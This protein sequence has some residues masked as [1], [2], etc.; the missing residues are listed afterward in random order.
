MSAVKSPS[1]QPGAKVQS[2]ERRGLQ[3][4]ALETPLKGAARF[5]LHFGILSWTQVQPDNGVSHSGEYL[6]K[7]APQ[8]VY[9]ATSR[10]LCRVPH[11]M[12]LP[13]L[14]KPFQRYFE[15]ICAT[16]EYL[17]D[18]V[19]KILEAQGKQLF[20][21]KERQ[22]TCN[23]RRIFST[24]HIGEMSATLKS[25]LDSFGL[26]VQRFLKRQRFRSMLD[27]MPVVRIRTIDRIAK[28]DD[29]TS[30]R[31]YGVNSRGNCRLEE[32]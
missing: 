28:Y 16:P 22:V 30:F 20:P 11:A 2:C 10:H 7:P 25:Y 6:A 15:E 18:V 1:F 19:N 12:S 4:I 23:L 17:G 9:D 8:V 27:L 21:R 14:R 3:D 24:A 5:T 31:D 29:E 13:G 32:I 26:S